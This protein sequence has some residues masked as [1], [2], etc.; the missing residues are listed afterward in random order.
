MTSTLVVCSLL[1]LGLLAFGARHGQRWL[2]KRRRRSA[3]RQLIRDCKG[4]QDLAER[5]MWQE[6][7]QDPELSYTH[8]ARLAS[9]RLRRDRR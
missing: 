9:A 6:M 7:S 5:L 2:E 8:A 4:D 1:A 3:V